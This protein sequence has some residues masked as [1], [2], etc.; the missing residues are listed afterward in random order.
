MSFCSV[1]SVSITY[2]NENKRTHH[3]R[4][5]FFYSLSTRTQLGLVHTRYVYFDIVKYHLQ[6]I[7]TF[8]N[9]IRA[10]TIIIRFNMFYGVL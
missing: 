2:G 10:Y 6:I 9:Y 1:L 5:Q 8:R 4:S 3:T 7:I